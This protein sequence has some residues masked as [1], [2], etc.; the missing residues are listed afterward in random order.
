MTRSILDQNGIGHLNGQENYDE[1][2]IS[3][4]FM[5][6]LFNNIG[7][8]RERT[9][10]KH[11]KL[12]SDRIVVTFKSVDCELTELASGNVSSFDKL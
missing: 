10:V 2:I 6:E 9:L 3:P 5:W 8:D 4:M 1:I 12:I 11:L 7:S